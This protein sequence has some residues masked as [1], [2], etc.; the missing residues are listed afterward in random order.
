[1]KSTRL[2]SLVILA[3][4]VAAGCQPSDTPPQQQAPATQEIPYR[5]DGT[6]H[7]LRENERMLT[8]DIEIADTDST[9][10]R[11]LMQRTSLPDGAGMLFIMPTEE[12]QSFWMANTPLS[13]DFVFASTSGEVVAISKYAKPQS[14]DPVMSGLPARFVLEV[15]AGFL[16]SYGIIE[17]DQ[18]EWSRTE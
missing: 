15:P 12:P 4:V 8:I 6:L 13:L 18:I 16:D 14:P 11:G 17:G 3:A 2:I 7:F 5:K 9:R 10:E 1:M